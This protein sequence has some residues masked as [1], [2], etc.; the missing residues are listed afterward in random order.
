MKWKYFKQSPEHNNLDSH[1]NGE[2]QQDTDVCLG[3]A[4]T[5][6]SPGLSIM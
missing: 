3:F 1:F 5:A 6:R 4:G 2:K